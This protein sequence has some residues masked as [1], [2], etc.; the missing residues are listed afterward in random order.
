VEVLDFCGP[1][2]FFSVG[3]RFTEPP[4]FTVLTVNSRTGGSLY[5]YSVS[6]LQS[7]YRG[8]GGRT[9]KMPE[10]LH[11]IPLAGVVCEQWF[12]CGRPGCR[13]ARGQRHG[14]YYCRLWRENGRLRKAYV[15]RSQ[16]EQVR[17]Q[18]EARRQPRRDLKAAWATWRE[19]RATVREAEQQ[20]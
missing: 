10:M 3:N 5:R 7:V 11:K 17:A 12:R 9:E 18:C 20:L 19:L 4:A 6:K 8:K 14:P 15:K 1:F 13:C 2:E 16:V